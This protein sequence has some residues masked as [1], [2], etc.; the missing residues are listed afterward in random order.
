MNSSSSSRVE[1]ERKYRNDQQSPTVSASIIKFLRIFA[2]DSGQISQ[3]S[4]FWLVDEFQLGDD[5]VSY[6]LD[7][8]M[9]DSNRFLYLMLSINKFADLFHGSRFPR[10]LD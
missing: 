10:M 1:G 9:E 3:L 5:L 7:G 8:S 2:G 4:D 6:S